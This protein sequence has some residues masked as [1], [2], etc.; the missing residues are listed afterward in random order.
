MEKRAMCTL[1]LL[2]LSLAL[3]GTAWAEEAA[4]LTEAD[5]IF[6]YEDV[7]Y[8]LLSDPAPL[9]AAIE[10]HDGQAMER[11]EAPSCLCAGMDREF[12]GQDVLLATHPSGPG[13]SDLL[14]TIV[15]LG[16]PWQTAR[17]IGV[18]STRDEVIAAYG[19]HFMEDYDQLVYALALP[20]ESPMLIFQMDLDTQ[21]VTAVFLMAFSS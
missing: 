6:S 17:G 12:A 2:C 7:D 21:L 15:I 14:E 9:I 10:A 8:A 18:G 1:L 20:Y 3:P 4:P 11:T 13:G 16:G 5:L 19:P